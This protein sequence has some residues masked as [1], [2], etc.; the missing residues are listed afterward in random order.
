MPPKI[1][2]PVTWQQAELLMQPTFI[3]VLDNIRKLLDNS[4]WTGTYQD[5]LIWSADTTDE[6]KAIVMRLLQELETA[7]PEEQNKIRQTLAKLPTPHPGYHLSLQRQEQ[8]VSVDLWELCYQVCFLDYSSV[9]ATVD[10]D[11]SLIDEMGD[12]DWQKLDF[13]VRELVEQVFENLPE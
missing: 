5:V 9:N 3:R 8:Q 2:N 7:T 6:T 11:T 4:T 10:V 1:N 13:K 12:V